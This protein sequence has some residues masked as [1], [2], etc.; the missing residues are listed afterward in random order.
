MSLWGPQLPG[1]FNLWIS[2]HMYAFDLKNGRGR[3]LKSTISISVL[4]ITYWV[5][6]DEEVWYNGIIVGFVVI[7]SPVK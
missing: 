7:G 5:V 6:V 2:P 1:V 3:C 4:L